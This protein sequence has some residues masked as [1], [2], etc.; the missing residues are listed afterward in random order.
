MFVGR[1][2]KNSRM[3]GPNSH[4]I[5]VGNAGKFRNLGN[6]RFRDSYHTTSCQNDGK[7]TVASSHYTG[8]GS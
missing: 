6:A 8:R 7:R 3:Y 4:V 2:A 5:V 1:L